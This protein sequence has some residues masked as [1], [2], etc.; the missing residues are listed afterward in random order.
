MDLIFRHANLPDGRTNI[1]VGIKGADIAA[2]A[3]N[4]PATAALEVD[5]KV[6]LL[7]PPFVDAH[8]HLD[9]ALSLGLPRLNRSGT[10]LEGIA[11]W[12]ELKPLLT[13]EALVERALRYCDLA[14]AQGVL[15]IRSHGDVSDPPP[16]PAEGW[17]DVRARVKP[18]IDL[19][20]V[21]FPQ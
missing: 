6:K 3:E 21:A 8:F 9:A 15:A 17:L 4:L 1:D 7:S 13:L 12:G 20:L 5:A 10:L 11:L 14:V 16:L 18:Y 19:Q 2:V